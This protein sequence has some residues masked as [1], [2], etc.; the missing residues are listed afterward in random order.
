MAQKFVVVCLKQNR[1]IVVKEAWVQNPVVGDFS[2]VFFS[3]IERIPDFATEESFYFNPNVGGCYLAFVMK[4]FADIQSANK[5]IA[6]K[7]PKFPNSTGN[8]FRF[9]QQEIVDQISI[10]DDEDAVDNDNG[11]GDVVRPVIGNPATPPTQYKDDAVKIE[12]E[13][14]ALR[15]AV[16]RLQ[17][18]VGC[19]VI[20]DSSDS[21]DDGLDDLI[22]RKAFTTHYQLDLEFSSKYNYITN[23][24]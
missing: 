21:D 5:Y 1:L 4:I 7:R 9:A 16:N 19:E 18:L 15:R 2:K 17:S 12:A 11:N 10:C 3:P 14:I 6:W 20:S 24:N 8:K 22:K 23:V 13:N